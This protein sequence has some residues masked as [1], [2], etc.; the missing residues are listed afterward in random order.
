V[1]DFGDDENQTNHGWVDHMGEALDEIE[2]AA[3]PKALVTTGRGKFYS[4]GLDTDYMAAN[5]DDVLAYVTRVEQVCVR[6][7]LAP[8]PTAAAVNG[9]AFG[10]GA[11]LAIAQD[12]AVMRED[13][14]WIC[15]P[16]IDLGMSFPR[17]LLELG[18]SRLEPRVLHEAFAT[19]RRYTAAEG[20]AAGF[21]AE[22]AP[23]VQVLG[24]AIERVAPLARQA[25]PV[26]GRIK[27]QIHRAVVDAAAAH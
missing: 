10:I 26:L 25:G 21:V 12:R 2:R 18:R 19:G 16:E 7:L 22:A 3:G 1:I 4:A 27:R 23:E 11:F 17:L 15:F 24:R 9:H 8:L 20:I 13:R 14:G 5:P 6:L